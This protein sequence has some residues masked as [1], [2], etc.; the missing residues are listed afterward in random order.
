MEITQK[1]RYTMD[2]WLAK[3]CIHRCNV[4]I[5]K[6]KRLIWNNVMIP[7]VQL[8]PFTQLPVLFFFLDE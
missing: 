5:I 1:T 6:V 4:L 3:Y 8:V 7:E 2:G